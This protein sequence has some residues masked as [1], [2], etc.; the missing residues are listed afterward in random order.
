MDGIKSFFDRT[1]EK[2]KEELVF[3]VLR[4]LLEDKGE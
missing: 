4:S 3:K 2:N 1:I